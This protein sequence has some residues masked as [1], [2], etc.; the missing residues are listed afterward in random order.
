MKP[1]D[2][3]R[4]MYIMQTGAGLVGNGLLDS[5]GELNGDIVS[6]DSLYQ[7]SGLRQKCS[8]LHFQQPSIH[9]TN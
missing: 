5:V 1:G 9:G 3:D 8:G 4:D 2:G 7:Q 6:V